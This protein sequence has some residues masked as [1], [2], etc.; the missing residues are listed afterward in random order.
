MAAFEGARRRAA[1]GEIDEA[2]RLLDAAGVR[3][4]EAEPAFGRTGPN[5]IL[6]T[7]FR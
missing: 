4:L 7:L 5:T 3:G 6:K 1:A 2:L